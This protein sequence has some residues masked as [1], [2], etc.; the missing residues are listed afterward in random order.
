MPEYPDENTPY[1]VEYRANQFGTVDDLNIEDLAALS[2]LNIDMEDPC[3]DNTARAEFAA[4]ALVAF[5]ERVGG[6]ED[7]ETYLGDLLGDL[8]HL[9]DATGVDWDTV[10]DRGER[11]YA[12]EIAGVL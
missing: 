4:R 8:H 1:G 12:D 7:I 5:A 11:Y 3:Q 2:R 9:C 10:R 6:S